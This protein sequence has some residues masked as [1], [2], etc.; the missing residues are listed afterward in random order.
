MTA[1][2]MRFK[3]DSSLGPQRATQ[4][5]ENMHFVVGAF[6]STQLGGGVGSTHA[7]HERD[8]FFRRAKHRPC[9]QEGQTG[10]CGS[11]DKMSLPFPALPHGSTP[12]HARSKLQAPSD[13]RHRPAMPATSR[14]PRHPRPVCVSDWVHLALGVRHLSVFTAH[15]SQA[16][17]QA[18]P[19]QTPTSW[20]CGCR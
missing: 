14:P 16:Q 13:M 4:R 8:A 20:C 17:E 5:T 11:Y 1:G 18:L 10:A 3:N 9:H 2:G 12:P 15:S 7:T 6:V 19:N